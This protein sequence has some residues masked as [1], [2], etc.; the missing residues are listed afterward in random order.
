MYSGGPHRVLLGFNAPFPLIL[1]N[2][3]G[4]RGWDK[5][6]NE[7]LD[8]EVNL[9]WAGELNF[10]GTHFQCSSNINIKSQSIK[11]L[12]MFSSYGCCKH[13]LLSSAQKLWPESLVQ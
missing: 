3:E 4:D 12:M 8:R 5:K 1:L 2:P 11:L 9:N 7:D 13:S 6:E 10:R